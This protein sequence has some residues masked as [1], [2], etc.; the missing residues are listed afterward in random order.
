MQV[1]N[2]VK[3][4]TGERTGQIEKGDENSTQH[5]KECRK[6]GDRKISKQRTTT[7]KRVIG[8]K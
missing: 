5:W 3:F 4:K 8:E 7:K 2:M 1:E 6:V